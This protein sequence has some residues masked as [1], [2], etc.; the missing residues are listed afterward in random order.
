MLLVKEKLLSEDMNL[1]TLRD[2]SEKFNNLGIS[3]SIGKH[4]SHQ[5]KI[6]KQ[7]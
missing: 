2:T 5:V 6:Y 7:G 4:L 3:L 1:Q